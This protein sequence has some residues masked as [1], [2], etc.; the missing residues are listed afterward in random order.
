[1]PHFW[2]TFA[3]S[4]LGLLIHITG[5]LL[6]HKQNDSNIYGTQKCLITTLSLTEMSF[7]TITAMRDYIFFKTDL[8]F[9]IGMLVSNYKTIVLTDMYYF[10]MFG[11]AIDRFM[12]VHLNI[13]YDLYW[14]TKKTRK[15]LLAFFIILNSLY[16]IYLVV[17]LSFQ[18]HD[19]P[20][21]VLQNFHCYVSPIYYVSFLI[22]AFGVY[23]YIFKLIYKNQKALKS[24]MK[25]ITRIQSECH[26]FSNT[27]YLLPFW[28]IITFIMFQILPD[29]LLTINILLDGRF[30]IVR[31]IVVVLLR[32]GFIVD[33]VIYIFNLKI[34]KRGIKKIKARISIGFSTSSA[35]NR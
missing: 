28:I 2:V 21:Q 31:I 1:M 25:N 32:I 24:A 5:L 17:I 19:L 4:I 9:Y 14:N 35:E 13:K 8:S 20:Y 3:F 26:S 27:K 23:Y 11:I 34:V 10:T 16:F 33:P 7:L 22:T 6:L 18:R 15:L 30:N 12:Q 29:V